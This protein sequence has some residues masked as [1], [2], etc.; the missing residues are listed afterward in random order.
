MI[1]FVISLVIVALVLGVVMALRMRSP[2]EMTCS[3]CGGEGTWEGVR[4]Q[5]RCDACGGT[6]RVQRTGSR[7]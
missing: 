2:R 3:K 4:M 7:D 5:E 1:R 6:G